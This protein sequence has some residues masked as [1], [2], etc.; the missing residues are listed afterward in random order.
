[1]KGKG[2]GA[3]PVGRAKP[4]GAGVVEERWDF[5]RDAYDRES[6][7]NKLLSVGLVVALVLLPVS[8]YAGKE[9]AAIIGLDQQG[10][11]TRIPKLTESHVSDASVRRFCA[12]SVSEVGTFAFHDFTMRLAQISG[13]FTENG[14]RSFNKALAK[15]KIPESVEAFTQT[16]SMVPQEL[17]NILDQKVKDGRYWWDLKVKVRRRVT[18][19]GKGTDRELNIRLEIVRV[20]LSEANELIAIDK[21]GEE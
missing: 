2:A 21:W 1:M 13:R 12:E 11:A 17:C 3:P 5:F 8:F 19:G 14:W 15:S 10:R 18:S 9:E 16:Y 6:G 4:Q 20:G 7:K